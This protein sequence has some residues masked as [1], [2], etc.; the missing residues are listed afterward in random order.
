M[1]SRMWDLEGSS[2]NPWLT[3]PPASSTTV[4]EA[5]TLG[6]V[7]LELFDADP[8]EDG[9]DWPVGVG[10][11]DG[12]VAKTVEAEEVTGAIVDGAP[13]RETLDP[14]APVEG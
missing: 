2:N 12:A 3:Y 7:D 9:T 4:G 1:A 14:N 10:V 6:T 8:P 11:D 13:P 5:L